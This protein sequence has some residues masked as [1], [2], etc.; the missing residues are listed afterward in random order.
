ME[1]VLLGGLSVLHKKLRE[2]G[3]TIH[4]PDCA[5]VPSLTA[6]L[7]AKPEVAAMAICANEILRW[8]DGHILAAAKILQA[9]GR[10]VLVGSGAEQ[11]AMSTLVFR[12]DT[13]EDA[14]RLL[15]RPRGGAAATAAKKS[16]S[17]GGSTP[18]RQPAFRPLPL[19]ISRSRILMIH[20]VGSQPRIGC[21]TQAIA[22]WHYFKAAGM[23]PAVVMDEANIRLLADTMSGAKRI[24]GGCSINGISFVS[25][26]QQAYDCYIRD[27]SFGQQPNHGKADA[28]VLVAGSKPWELPNTM[29][30]VRTLRHPRCAAVFSFT[31]N[32]EQ[33]TPLLRGTPAEVAPYIPDPWLTPPAMLLIYDRL[34][35]S[36][37]ER[38]PIE[39]NLE[40]ELSSCLEEPQETLS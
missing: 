3:H 10:L 27:F 30:A 33:L 11:F 38:A 23:D 20:V 29:Q 16:G 28:V 12:V 36:L 32:A 7:L 40:E 21:T 19:K 1:I 37:L 31:D 5:G 15:T 25:D 17:D 22:L 26:T 24:N 34:L 18:E 6:L 4:A 14:L 13:E 2:L 39:E 8:S 35:R 9:R